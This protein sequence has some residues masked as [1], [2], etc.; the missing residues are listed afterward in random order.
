MTFKKPSDIT[1]TQCAMYIDAHVYEPDHD[2]D[3]IFQYLYHLFYILSVKKCYFNKSIDYDG[4]ALYGAEQVYMRLTNPKQFLP[5]G[6]PKKLKKVKS[7]LNYIKNVLYAF[8][9]NYQNSSFREVISGEITG[10]NTTNDVKNDL[11]AKA[12]SIFA[13]QRESETSFYL[14][15]ISNTIRNY[16]KNIPFAS[17]KLTFKNIYISCLLTLLS[18]ITWSNANKA[19]VDFR[20]SKNLD[21]TD[22]I[23]NIYKD[24]SQDLILYHLDNSMQ[25]Y[26][27]VLVNKLKTLICKDLKEI[28]GYNEPT[29][30][31]IKSIIASPFG[32]SRE[33]QSDD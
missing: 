5:D 32:E 19:K 31:V 6:D 33:Q 8:K 30:Q 4:Y 3:K 22:T 13:P 10:D 17:D 28:I 21:L 29:E 15:K 24:E 26:I 7:C 27:K 9:V 11:E 16:L 14:N 2:A 12:Y 20:N 18:N 1:Y 25:G 23:D